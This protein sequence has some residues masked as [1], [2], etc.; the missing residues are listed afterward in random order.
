MLSIALTLAAKDLRL[1]IR[2]RTALALAFLLPIVLGT[3]MGA[4][5]GG[6]MGEMIPKTAGASHAF[7]SMAVMML[8]FNL[9]AAA[10]TLQEER[11][12]GTLD[13]LRLTPS[14]GPAIL[15]GKLISAMTMAVVQ[16]LVLFV[17][18][19][20]TFD[21]PVFENA[22]S[23][24]VTSVIWAFAASSLGLLF[25]TATKTR[26]QM[27]G[28]STLVIL[29]MSALGGA[30][31]PREVTPDWFQAVGLVT[32]VAWAMD[33]YHEILWFGASYEGGAT[34]GGGGGPQPGGP[35]ALVKDL[36]VLAAMGAAMLVASAYFY[37]RRFLNR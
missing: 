18:G 6:A 11:A 25:A 20:L 2:D 23:L 12:E 29:A 13:R 8:M 28:L 17:F 27:E 24:S 31:F 37:R 16:L 34:G 1:F 4:G 21:V 36:S 33:A 30:W 35:G 10:G 19:A 32:P 5:L 3:A 26:K 9:V 7:S 14:A 22:A 15:L